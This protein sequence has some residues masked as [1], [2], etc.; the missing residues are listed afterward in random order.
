MGTFGT[1]IGASVTLSHAARRPMNDRHT[2]HPPGARLADL[3]PLRLWHEILIGL[4]LFGCYVFVDLVR[5]PESLELANAHARSLFRLEESLGIDI[6]LAANTWLVGHPTLTVWANHEYTYGYLVAPAILLVWAYVRRPQTYR[7]L[8]TSFVV[9]TF[10]AI[11]TF[12]LWPLTPPRM[13]GELGLTDTVASAGTW[14]SWGS[15]WIELANH[16][17]AMPSL[18]VAWPLWVAIELM[19]IPLGRWGWVRVLSVANVLLTT[20]ATIITANHFVLDVV[21]AVVLVPLAMVIGRAWARRPRPAGR[22]VAAADAFY[23]YVEQDA[24]QHVGGVALLDWNGSR[25]PTLREVRL[26]VAGTLALLPS[27]R[28]R[29]EPGTRWR[30]PRWVEVDDIDLGEHVVERDLGV[31]SA[32]GSQGRRSL[33]ELLAELAETPLPSNRPMWRVVLVH[34]VEPHRSALVLLAHHTVADGLGVVASALGLFEPSLSQRRDASPPPVGRLRRAAGVVVGVAQLATDGSP[35]AALQE[36][37]TSRR[38]MVV[39]SVDLDAIR[40]VARVHG[41][42]VT[43]V[44]LCAVAGAL[45]RNRP[46]LA[47]RIGSQ[48]R[49]VVPLLVAD[50]TLATGNLTG[51]VMVDLPLEPMDEEDRLA[52]AAARSARLTTPSRAL[53]SRAVVSRGLA[54]VP[55]PAA[56]WFARTVYGHRFFHGIVSNMAGPDEQLWLGDARLTDVM[57][58][59]PLAPGAPFAVG[60]LGWNGRLGIGVMTDPSILPAEE[61][62]AGV[63]TVLDELISRSR[64]ERTPHEAR[65]EV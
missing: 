57:P 33:A 4:A 7:I 22:P 56:R 36:R 15:S 51:G 46:D 23:W 17:A 18:H 24:P 54:V 5:D 42:R 45:S 26:R 34:G 13:L 65:P 2:S 59:V 25:E 49:V 19:W 29:L 1:S 27:L 35:S 61:L 14:G 48:L 58:I 62:C 52:S 50:P 30:R 20:T 6:E 64:A 21:A 28:R 63:V 39:A 47:A 9:L 32:N 3:P 60:A 55:P 10:I 8:R 40:R 44:L 12:L 11:T 16:L 38:E 41:G 43:D 31:G 53:A 37:S